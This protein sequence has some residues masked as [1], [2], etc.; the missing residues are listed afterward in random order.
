[1]YL[2]LNKKYLEEHRKDMEKEAQEEMGDSGKDKLLYKDEKQAE[3]E[4][5]EK[6]VITVSCDSKIGFL[7]ID[8]ELDDE[9]IFTLIEYMKEKANKIKKL[10]ILADD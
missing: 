4:C 9:D 7:S 3:I 1:M 5:I 6:N 2:N 8:I 10:L